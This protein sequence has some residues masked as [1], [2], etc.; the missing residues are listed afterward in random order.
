MIAYFNRFE[1]HMTKKQ[2]HFASHQGECIDD[3]REL[4]KNR[5]IA[6]QFEKIAPYA[7]KAELSEYGA[8]DEVELS[9]LQANQERILWIASGDIVSNIPNNKYKIGV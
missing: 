2:A 3:V 4:L 5:D 1:L 9:D 8:W 7:I 6:R